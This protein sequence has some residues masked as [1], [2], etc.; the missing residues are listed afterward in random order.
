MKT[1]KLRILFE[2]TNLS[3]N[4]LKRWNSVQFE[5]WLKFCAAY[6]VDRNNVELFLEFGKFFYTYVT[7]KNRIPTVKS[8][9]KYAKG[10]QNAIYPDGFENI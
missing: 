1:Y 9:Q 3:R 5:I 7:E 2:A 10:L 4:D 8:F 6:G